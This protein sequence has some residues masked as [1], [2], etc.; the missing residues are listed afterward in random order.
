MS[1]IG[2]VGGTF[3]FFHFGHQKLISS[4]LSNCDSLEIWVLS[5]KIALQKD[6]RISSWFDRCNLIRHSLS[7][8]E[9]SRVTFH[10]LLDEF[11]VAT[12]H[13]SAKMIFCTDD[14]LST[15]QKINSMR[16]KEGLYPLSIISVPHELSENGEI[17]S[18]S[19][20]RE[21]KMDR[22]GKSWFNNQII[23]SELYLTKEVESMLKDPFGKLFEGPE[24]D[25]SVAIKGALSSLEEY[26]LP[27]I[28][29]G[30]VT[31][32]ALQNVSSGA[33][34]AIIDEKTKRVKWDGFKEID[35]SLFDNVLKCENPPGLLTKSLFDTCKKAVNNWMDKDQS[36]LIIVDG[37]EDLAPI[38]LHILAPIK[39]A[40]I[41]G[42]PNKGVVVR[43]TGLDSKRRC[44]NILSLCENKNN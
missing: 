18:S 28:G 10:E 32:R 29:V 14:T 24:E 19:R 5:D 1:S 27:I 23:E 3:D 26:N 6:P 9:N 25:H 36:T 17:I 15:C 30:D 37:E 4:C 11:G 22:D 38:F 13:P 35:Q 41:Y 42:Q 7:S 12:S 8:E 34:I 20:I 44:R 43:I 40:I 21:G 31:V 2:L 16:E 39:S 33:T